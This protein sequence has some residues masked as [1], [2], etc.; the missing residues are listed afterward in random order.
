MM[1]VIGQPRYVSSS[2]ELRRGV[3]ACRSSAGPGRGVAESTDPE[4][5]RHGRHVLRSDGYADADSDVVQG[6]ARADFRRSRDER[7]SARATGRSQRGRRRFIHLHVQQR[8]R[9]HLAPHQTRHSGSVGRSLTS[10]VSTPFLQRDAMQARPM[11][12]CGVCAS[13]CLSVTFVH[14]VK[15]NKHIFTGRRM[16]VV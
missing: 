12:S 8:R 3:H 2:V 9:L 10:P 14:S 4:R 5:G 7:R 13:V 11:P 16:Q 15:T 6:R 1:S